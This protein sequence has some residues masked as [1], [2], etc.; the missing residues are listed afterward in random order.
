MRKPYFLFHWVCFGQT[1]LSALMRRYYPL[2]CDSISLNK[3]CLLAVNTLSPHKVS[4]IL[5][6]GS[7]GSPA[8]RFDCCSQCSVV[9]SYAYDKHTPVDEQ[10]NISN[11]SRSKIITEI[12]MKTQNSLNINLFYQSTFP[13]YK[14]QSV[15]QLNEHI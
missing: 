15:L 3:N 13:K 11:I 1:L 12:R 14:C 2:T 10:H 6:A 5:Y 9:K 7:P 8:R 4:Y